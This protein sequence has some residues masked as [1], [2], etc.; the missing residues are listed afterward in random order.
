MCGYGPGI[1]HAVAQHFGEQGFGV[2][3]AARRADNVERAAKRFV[4]AGIR[5]RGFACDLARPAAVTQLMADVRATLGPIDVVHWNA[6]SASAG[7]L[8]TCDVRELQATLDVGVV[9][10][11]A[12][13][14]A[15]LPDLRAQPDAA[16]LVTG[17]GLAR[18][19]AGM[20]ALAS[21]IGAMG[22]AVAKAAQHK[23]VSVLHP[24]LSQ[25]G[26]FVGEVMVMG[27]VKG[28]AADR[29]Q[30]SLEPAVIAQRFWELYQARDAACV[31]VP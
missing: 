15:A 29:G 3:L 22:L 30:A 5:A 7:D 17:G 19:D 26:V 31:T 20:N 23:L 13:V 10:L 16:V 11:T 24:L 6:Y 1:S 14:Q 8:T 12:A 18:D 28:T 27:A 2:A 25:T 9:G 4:D 21:Q